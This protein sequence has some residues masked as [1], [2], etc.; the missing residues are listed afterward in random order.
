MKIVSAYGDRLHRLIGD[1]PTSL[2]QDLKFSLLAAVTVILAAIPHTTT[3]IHVY[4]RRGMYSKHFLAYFCLRSQ[5]L[6]LA[7]KIPNQSKLD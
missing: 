1:R 4:S 5:L 7:A 2:D 3:Q 6:F